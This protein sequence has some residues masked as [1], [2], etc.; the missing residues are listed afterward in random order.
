[1]RKYQIRRLPVVDRAGKLVGFVSLND[2]ARHTGHRADDLRAEGV[3]QT[4]NA[5]CQPH[6]RATLS[7]A[8]E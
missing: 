1:M 3:A 5:I 2:L 8:A 7:A 6:P 4:L